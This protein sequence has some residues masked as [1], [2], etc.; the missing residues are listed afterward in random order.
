M[1]YYLLKCLCL[2]FEMCKS[3]RNRFEKLPGY[4]VYHLDK[5]IVK[6]LYKLTSYLFCWCCGLCSST[7]TDKS[8]PY[9]IF[10]LFMPPKT[11]WGRD[12]LM[13]MINNVENED[14][15]A[16][17]ESKYITMSRI[18]CFIGFIASSTYTLSVIN[19]NNDSACNWDENNFIKPLNACRQPFHV[20]DEDD[21]DHLKNIVDQYPYIF[22]YTLWSFVA[23]AIISVILEYALEWGMDVHFV[24]FLE[25]PNIKLIEIIEDDKAKENE[26]E[27]AEAETKAAIVKVT[28]EEEKQRIAMVKVLLLQNQINPLNIT[29]A[30]KQR[31]IMQVKQLEYKT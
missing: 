14:E 1:L 28:S 21:S 15:D 9:T 4:L 17:D 25:G 29:E 5:A 30:E 27:E 13:K 12:T 23:L 24:L 7:N 22:M 26:D 8:S 20:N 16:R 19:C 10:K 6:G 3:T 31:I 18:L 11:T 2:P